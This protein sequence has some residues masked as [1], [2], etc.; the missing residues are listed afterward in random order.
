MVTT[1]LSILWLL[2]P[3]EPP[4]TVVDWFLPI[5]A[6][7]RQSLD[8]VRLTGI[9]AFGRFRAARP[10]VAAH[11]HTGADFMRPTNDY[12]NSPVYPAAAG[13]VISFRED[14]PFTK[15]VIEHLLP[16][17]E[18]CW[19]VYEHLQNLRIALGQTVSPTQPIGRFMTRA[20]LDR[21]G[22]QFDHL[23]FEVLKTNPQRQKVNDKNPNWQF[24]TYTL[25]CTTPEL[26]GLHYENPLAFFQTVWKP[27]AANKP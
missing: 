6:R 21:Y 10:S 13:K 20:E 17:G 1:L 27:S 16:H 19:T 3:T 22:W 2:V 4:L 14:G 23:H 15:V 5:A 8:A 24:S 18:K 7:D 12:A 11:L 25:I 26:L 9:G